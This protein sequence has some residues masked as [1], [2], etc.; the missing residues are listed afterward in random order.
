[1]T[2]PCNGLLM[3]AQLYLSGEFKGT[4]S[5]FRICGPYNEMRLV[6]AQLDK[7]QCVYYPEHISLSW[8]RLTIGVD[9]K[10]KALKCFE[11]VLMIDGTGLDHVV[12]ENVEAFE[13]KEITTI[14]A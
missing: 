7:H 1:M 13:P 14:Y 5:A 2:S 9:E 3:P 10:T 12:I 8:T 4:K 11:S 6:R